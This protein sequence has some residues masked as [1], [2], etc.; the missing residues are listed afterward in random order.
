M[1]SCELQSDAGCKRPSA[2][3]ETHVDAP[4]VATGGTFYS[5]NDTKGRHGVGDFIQN[6]YPKA[7][8]MPRPHASADLGGFL[9]H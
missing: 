9:L 4:L 3:T 8:P 2:A 7:K 6:V 1:D 5:S